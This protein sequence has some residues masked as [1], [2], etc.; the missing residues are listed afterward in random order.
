[1]SSSSTAKSEPTGWTGWVM[2]SALMMLMIGSF[3]AVSGLAA[4]VENEL[5]VTGPGGAL[6]VDM[7]AWGWVHLMLGAAV[8]TVGVFL[9]RGAGWARYA[10]IGLVMLNM[11]TQML[12]LPA[13]PLWALVVIAVD[14]LVLW[15]LIVHGD[16]SLESLR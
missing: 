7:S 5:F 1:M 16:E 13:Y 6:L 3:N 12:V 9:L 10:A 2:F 8:A 14:V 4:V 11:V 15:A